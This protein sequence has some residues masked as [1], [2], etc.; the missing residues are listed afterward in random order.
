MAA[1]V[2]VEE[3]AVVVLPHSHPANE[4]KDKEHHREHEVS[5]ARVREATGRN[6]VGR[7]SCNRT[8]DL[9]RLM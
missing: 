7:R 8:T 5:E 1:V 6:D 4:D 2:R 3:V 9:L